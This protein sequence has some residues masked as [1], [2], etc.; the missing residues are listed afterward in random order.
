MER[1]ATP[2]FLDADD[3]VFAAT[4]SGREGAIAALPAPKKRTR[5]DEWRDRD[6]CESFGEYL[7][8]GKLPKFERRRAPRGEKCDRFG[9]QHRMFRMRDAYWGDYQREIEGDWLPTMKEAKASYKAKLKAFNA[10]A[11]A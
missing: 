7:C 1:R 6:G 2:K 11:A 8:G 5:A 9:D 4:D 3:I 10:R